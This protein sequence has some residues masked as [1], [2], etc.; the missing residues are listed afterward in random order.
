MEHQIPANF[1]RPAGG[2]VCRPGGLSHRERERQ[3][4]IHLKL[5]RA[6]LRERAVLATG[7]ASLDAALDGGLPRG[8][9]TEIFGP[10]SSGKT[11]F[12]LQVAAGAQYA[13]L[14]AAWIDAEHAFNPARAAQ[15]GVSLERLPVVRPET[16][17]ECLEMARQLAGSGGLDLLVID[18]AAALAP[19]LELEMGLGDGGPSLQSRV[20]ASGL[21]KLAFAAAKTETT[22]LVFNQIRGRGEAADGQETSAGGPALKIYAAV[23][24]ALDAAEDGRVGFRIVKNKAASAFRRGQLLLESGGGFA[25]SP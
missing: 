6:D 13:G 25:E 7:I 22:V 11:T 3:R 10:P 4:T 18:S 24:V 2:P 19:A 16:A 21:R 15:L 8:L 17:E 1:E 12:G 20:L 14:S 5:A 23:R 9:L